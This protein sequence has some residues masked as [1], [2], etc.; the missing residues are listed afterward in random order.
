M[1]DQTF[2]Q[3]P[4]KRGKC[5][6]HHGPQRLTFTWWVCCSLFFDRNQPSTTFYSVLVSVSVFMALSTV[7]HSINCPDNSLFL[8]HSVR[9]VLF[10][11][12]GAFQLFISLWK[13]PS[14]LTKTFVV[15][16]AESTN[17][18]RNYYHKD[19]KREREG[20]GDGGL[21]LRALTRNFR[22][23]WNHGNRTG[24]DEMMNTI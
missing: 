2:S 1:N 24:N 8:S 13:S 16:W 21:Q 22:S 17:Y 5:H 15:D 20:G 6:H 7:F 9:P 19:E 23:S 4:R 3:N 10:P 12:Y 18:L 14:A 11:P